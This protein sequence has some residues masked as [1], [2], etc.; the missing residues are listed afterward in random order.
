FLAHS[1]GIRAHFSD[2]IVW[3]TI[4]QEAGSLDVA[5]K[6]NNL[7]GLFVRVK[8]TFT[9]PIIAGAR[10]AEVLAGRRVLVI[11][12]DVW[13]RPQLEPFLLSSVG[14]ATG[15][16]VLAVSRR[17][18][19]LPDGA[20][21]VRVPEMARE[22]AK[23]VLIGDLLGA[24]A[25]VVSRLMDLTGRWPVLLG[26]VNGAARAD[27]N[28]GLPVNDALA[29]LA[30][31]LSES[32]PNVLELADDVGRGR[33][34]T[35]TLH[36]GLSRLTPG[37]RDRYT[38]LAA[39]GANADIPR[40]VLER[41]WHHTGGWDRAQTRRF[42]QLITDLSLVAE[43]RLDR[44]DPRLRLHDIISSW[45]RHEAADRLPD[46]HARVVQAHRDLIPDIG[47]RSQWWVLPTVKA[48]PAVGYLWQWLPVHLHGAG[49]HDELTTLLMEP[50]WLLGKLAVT[51]P[52]GLE[53]DLVLSGRPVCSE[54]GRVVRQDG[55]LLVP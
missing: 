9:D 55:H 29:E 40:A 53:A 36:A 54:L 32:G 3:I 52:A 34:V 50:L 11:V 47:N 25:G 44:L 51:G 45:L 5:E 12:D 41:Y 39:F 38:E 28:A 26:F 23:Q 48:E 46:L 30:E 6:L 37:E 19:I 7:T 33:A 10:L 20:V 22:E 49:L 1:P 2:G 35:A 18:S 24:A 14:E 16:V 43:Y 13:Y 27:V 42:C 15:P 21:A 31:Q 8:P 4:G 17:R